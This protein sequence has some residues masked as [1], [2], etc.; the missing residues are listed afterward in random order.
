MD[1]LPKVSVIVPIYNVEKYLD[2]CLNSIIRQTL[3]DIEIICVDD[4]STDKSSEIL[5]KFAKKDPRII[6]FYKENGGVSSARNFGAQYANGKYIYFVDS[7]DFLDYKT[8][9]TLYAEASKND[10]DL[11]CFDGVTTCGNK[12]L[13][14]FFHKKYNIYK[15]KCEYNTISDGEFLF[16]KMLEN[17]DYRSVVFLQ[18]IKTDYYKEVGLSFWEG[19]IHEDILFS[20]LCIIQAKRV[21]HINACFYHRR[22]REFSIIT[23]PLGKE[24]I[25]GL[26]VSGIN[27][28]KFLLNNNCR[29]ETLKAIKKYILEIYK[30][31]NSMYS[32]L[33]KLEKMTIVFPAGSVEQ[34][35]FDLFFHNNESEE[36]FKIIVFI[37]NKIKMILRITKKL[38]ID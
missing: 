2:E 15:R 6:V 19:I 35:I 26:F 9:E 37:K 1:K 7:D 17:D 14:K 27:I 5:K 29:P 32:G 8:L 36:S 30:N 25:S 3:F 4:G 12:E 31:A 38:L 18:F 16:S 11:L 33:S 28:F 34:L 23:A 10:L 24:N 20:F 22:I 21:K 13:K